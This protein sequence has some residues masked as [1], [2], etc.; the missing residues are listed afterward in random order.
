MSEEE[1]AARHDD[2]R[3]MLEAAKDLDALAD[4]LHGVRSNPNITP[5]QAVFLVDEVHNLLVT[6]E[7][8]D[9]PGHRKRW[10]DR[11]MHGLG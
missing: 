11:A 4:A 2:S 10:Y 7:V 9:V 6:L 5:E 3:R 8:F 1:R